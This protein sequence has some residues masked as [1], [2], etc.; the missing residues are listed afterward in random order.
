MNNSLI[1][2]LLLFMVSCQSEY[3]KLVKSELES[4]VVYEDLIFDI[5]IGQTD[6]DFFKRCWELN[7]QKLISQGPRNRHV[8]YVMKPQE[9]P[10]EDE[11]VEMLFYAIFDDSN[12]I[13]GMKKRFSYLSWAPWNE[14]RHSPALIERLKNYYL[15]LYGG[16]DFIEV[17]IDG[18]D[19][20]SYV[21][22]DGNRQIL[23]FLADNKDVIVKIE[24][25]R[26]K[27]QKV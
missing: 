24:D 25:T 14:S 6:Q 1:L 17:E 18:S 22:V 15:Q 27:Y 10:D 7:N 23:M 4:G 26:F 3:D 12:I 21:K 11:E 16:N 13:R 9:I 20:T 8:R 2:I 19:V 5:K